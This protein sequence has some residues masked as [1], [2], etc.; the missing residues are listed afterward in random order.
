MKNTF[1]KNPATLLATLPAI[2]TLLVGLFAHADY[3]TVKVGVLTDLS[4][5][6]S[7][8]SGQGSILAAKMAME[9][10]LKAECKGMKIE[11]LSADHQNKADVAANQAREWIDTKGV[12]VIADLVNSSAA[13]AVQQIIKSKEKVALYNGPGSTKLTNEDCAPGG[14]HWMYDTYSLAAGTAKAMTKPGTSWFF[15][16][17]DYAFGQSLEKDSSAV[18][19]ANGGKVLGSVKHSF[20]GRD[21]SSYLLQAQASK[22]NII[23]LANAG[24][25]TIASIKQAKEF[26]IVQ[27]G[28]QLAGLLVFLSDVHSLGLATAQGLTTTEGFYW[29]YDEASRAWSKR[30]NDQLKRMPTMVHAGVYSSVLHYLKAVAA[31]KSTKMQTVVAKMKELPI[32]DGI[33]HN[34]KLRDDGR[35]VHDMLLL[36]VKKPEESKYPWDYYKVVSTIKGDDAFQPLSKS[37]CAAIKK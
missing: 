24:A 3:P 4:G 36:Q 17:A 12:D 20:P 18:V 22:S 33:I 6:Y 13:L 10:C 5:A 31:S 34:G 37:L 1:I 27:K 19:I 15:I 30:F 26:G 23:G 11:I 25:D 35:M 28:Q 14:I 21:F 8:L 16:T 9:D 7:D 32:K 2:L 29:D